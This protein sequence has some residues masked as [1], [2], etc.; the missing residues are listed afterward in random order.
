M[1]VPDLREAARLGSRPGLGPP[2]TG[3]LGPPPAAPSSFLHWQQRR[4]LISHREGL[5]D[6]RERESK[7]QRRGETWEEVDRNGGGGSQE[8]G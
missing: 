7:R 6:E 4:N 3:P 2:H 1:V 8:E 5:T